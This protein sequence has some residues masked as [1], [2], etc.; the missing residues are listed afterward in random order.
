MSLVR[1]CYRLCF[2]LFFIA[3]KVLAWP[4][5]PWPEENS[6]SP[7]LGEIQPDHDRYLF[8]DLTHVLN[9][10]SDPFLNFRKDLREGL[11]S[12]EDERKKWYVFMKEMYDA[13]L[14]L[15]S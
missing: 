9:I 4:F 2:G 10:V 11:A 3:F 12:S 13:R 7:V 5:G 14:L 15:G 8:S 1:K 6:V